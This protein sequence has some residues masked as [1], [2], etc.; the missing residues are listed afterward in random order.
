ML[1]QTRQNFKEAFQIELSAAIERAEKEVILA[2]HGFRLLELLDANTVAPG[3]PYVPYENGVQ[4]HQVLSDAEANLKEYQP[5]DSYRA[6]G[7][8]E[9]LEEHADEVDQQVNISGWGVA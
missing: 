5:D 8:S 2:K 1:L 7:R 4:A 9:I 6:P 3:E